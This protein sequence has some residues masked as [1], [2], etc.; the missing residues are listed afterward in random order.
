MNAVDELAVSFHERLH[1]R[2][3]NGLLKSA[4]NSTFDPPFFQ[5]SRVSLNYSER[6]FKKIYCLKKSIDTLVLR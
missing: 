4:I 2:Y 5:L 3:L 6:G 1:P